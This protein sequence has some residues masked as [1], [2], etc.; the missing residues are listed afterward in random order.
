M[1]TTLQE[2]VTTDTKDE[3]YRGTMAWIM[4]KRRILLGAAAVVVVVLLGV[5]FFTTAARRKEAFAMQAL[6][7]ARLTAEGGN[8][9]QASTQLQQVIATYP[10]T[11]AAHEAE[12]SLNQVRLINNQS[13]LA[14]VRLREFVNSGP[15]P[16]YVMAG[17]AL[18][19]AALENTGKAEEA[20]SAYEAA[21]Q[22][23]D[24][25]YLKAGYLIEAARA[26]D[27]AGRKDS[28]VAILRTV[29]EKYPETDKFTEAQVRLAELTGGRM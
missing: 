14:V 22:A 26:W 21:A 6:S 4:E 1:A 27:D 19:G 25:D 12:L 17:N 29:V 24:V 10:G 2:R 23:A 16:R 8:L 3:S 20:A 28:A 9:P 13:E 7:N 11:D 15:G 5:W 18:L